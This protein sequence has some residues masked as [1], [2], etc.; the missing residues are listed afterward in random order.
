MRNCK[1]CKYESGFKYEQI[2]ISWNEMCAFCKIVFKEEIQKV[3]VMAC[4]ENW[5]E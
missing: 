4:A 5:N 3:K 2:I 1:E